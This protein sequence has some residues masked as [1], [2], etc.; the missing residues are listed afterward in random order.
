[1]GCM[2]PEIS[3][4]PCPSIDVIWLAAS[5]G[6]DPA[7][8]SCPPAVVDAWAASWPAVL[9]TCPARVAAEPTPAGA[10]SPATA[11]GGT[12]AA[13]AIEPKVEAYNSPT[14]EFCGQ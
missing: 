11:G 10:T 3:C 1:M 4:G 7:L 5:E 6:A 8:A 12:A 2:T 13:A 14:L 9:P